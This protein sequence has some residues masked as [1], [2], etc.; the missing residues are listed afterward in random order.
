MGL[1]APKTSVI[2]PIS[3]PQW[4]AFIVALE[5]RFDIS[6]AGGEL[7]PAQ[8]LGDVA[9]H[10]SKRLDAAGRNTDLESIVRGLAQVLRIEFCAKVD[11]RSLQVCINELERMA[12]SI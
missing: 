10:I 2:G 7:Q 11:Q 4:L 9:T 8:K 3:G 5:E 6:I 12:S 1:F